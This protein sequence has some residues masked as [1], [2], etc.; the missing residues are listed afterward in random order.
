MSSSKPLD[1]NTLEQHTKAWADPF[2]KGLKPDDDAHT[3]TTTAGGDS[4]LHGAGATKNK[5]Y[6]LTHRS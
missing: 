1:K 2:K 3:V 5:K 6:F 4:S